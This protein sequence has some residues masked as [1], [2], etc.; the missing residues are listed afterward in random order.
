M[1]TLS[2]GKIQERDADGRP[3]VGVRGGDSVAAAGPNVKAAFAG[4]FRLADG[5]RAVPVLELVARQ[6]RF[7]FAGDVDQGEAR[8][9]RLIQG[10]AAAGQEL[11]IDGYNQLISLECLLLGDPLFLADD[12]VIRDVDQIG[13]TALAEDWI[14]SVRPGDNL[15]D[16]S[17]AHLTSM[18]YWRPLQPK[19]WLV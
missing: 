14:Y 3:L 11:V 5:R 18:K 17:E 10:E 8:R 13:A 12:G 16:L 7:R 19:P 1:W 9:A 15:W 4:T 2:H 6:H